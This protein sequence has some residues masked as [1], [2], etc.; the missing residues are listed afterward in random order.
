M[1]ST[2][3]VFTNVFGPLL[4]GAILSGVDAQGV[5]DF[6][7]LAVIASTGALVGTVIV[8]PIMIVLGRRLA[9]YDARA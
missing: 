2:I 8:V 1:S 6:G 3:L 5:A 7:R 9:L 4:G